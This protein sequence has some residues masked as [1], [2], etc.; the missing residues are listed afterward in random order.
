MSPFVPASSAADYSAV[1]V[2]QVACSLENRLL[3]GS[4]V[5]VQC[6]LVLEGEALKA[7]VVLDSASSKGKWIKDMLEALDSENKYGGH[8]ER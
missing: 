2:G 5:W 6:Q 8:V 1:S 7:D 4:V 3:V